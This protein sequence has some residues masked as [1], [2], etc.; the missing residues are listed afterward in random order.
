MLSWYDILKLIVPVTTAFAV[1]LTKRALERRTERIAK[2]EYLWR[3][4]DQGI[5]GLSTAIHAMIEI[6][7]AFKSGDVK[8]V[9]LDVPT[10]LA[11]CASRLAELDPKHA[12]IY[13]DYVSYAQIVRNDVAFL[14]ELIKI[15]LNSTN[16]GQSKVLIAIQA[17]IVA[18]I[19][20]LQILAKKEEKILTVLF[21]M[22]KKKFDHQ[23]I[24]KASK[25]IEEAGKIIPS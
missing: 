1:I 13:I 17:Q 18:V 2:A 25:D 7:D 21:T 12:Y 16:V 15:A 6:S 4:I 11:D 22:Y 9:Q 23:V 5:G 8:L 24:D 3:G 14:S 10:P 20:D 19:G